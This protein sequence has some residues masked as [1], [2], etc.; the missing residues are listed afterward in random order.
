MIR[1]TDI[2]L[3][4]DHLP[5]A[6]AEAVL[7]RLKITSAELI[8]CNIFRRA[9]DARKKSNI[10]LIYSLDVEVKQEA[11]ILKRFANDTN[12]K[13]TPDT[14]YKPVIRAPAHLTTRPLVIGAGPADCLLP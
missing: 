8:S 7:S 12:I 5:E 3:P 10:M 9:H 6:I 1:L 2:K 11:A 13:P 4:L 14:A